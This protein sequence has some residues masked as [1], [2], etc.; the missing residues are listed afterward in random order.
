MTTNKVYK[1]I[2]R[3]HYIDVAK[4]LLMII[5]IFHHL[6]QIAFSL[7]VDSPTLVHLDNLKYLYATFFMQT[8]FF[9][10]GYCSNFKKPFKEFATQTLKTILLPAIL[11]S[12]FEILL[13]GVKDP[14]M[15][16]ISKLGHLIYH[17]S[18][19]W[20]LNAI[21]IGRIIYWF[22]MKY[23]HNG[24]V[25]CSTCI[26]FTIIGVASFGR[27]PNLW[28]WQNALTCVFFLWFGQYF[29]KR[30][31]SYTTSAFYTS[32]LYCFIAGYIAITLCFLILGLHLPAINL[33]IRVSLFEIPIYL[34]LSIGGT[35]LY[36]LVTKKIDTNKFLEYLGYNSLIIYMIHGDILRITE[37]F[38]FS[39]I[40]MPEGVLNSLTFYFIIGTLTLLTCT[41]GIWILNKK[42]FKMLIGKF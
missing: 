21:F 31:S 23:I 3:I 14:E 35:F 9:I 11:F 33:N 17:G 36:L 15:E 41:I 26:I 13:W 10:N 25:K 40:G 29:K 16:I 27:V 42:Y 37:K 32:F 38:Y 8:F 2:G 4:G 30:N 7:G 1:P 5:L 28:D 39:V 22:L 24:F 34:I 12:A 18:N 19:F 20:F 6:P